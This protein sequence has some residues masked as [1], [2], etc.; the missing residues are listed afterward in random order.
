MSQQRASPTQFQFLTSDRAFTDSPDAGSPACL[1]SRCGDVI[2]EE[3]APALRVFDDELNV[4]YRYH[5]TCAGFKP[6]A[7]NPFHAEDVE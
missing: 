7:A 6:A 4:E 1:C 5:I 2:S 3:Q